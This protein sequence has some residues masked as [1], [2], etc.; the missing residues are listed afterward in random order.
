VAIEHHYQSPTSA[1]IAFDQTIPDVILGNYGFSENGLLGAVG[2]G[3]VHVNDPDAIYDMLPWQRWYALETSGPSELVLAGTSAKSTS[4]TTVTGTGTAYLTEVSAGDELVFPGG[5]VEYLQV[6][7]VTDDTHLELFAAPAHT[8][9][10]QT[11]TRAA[12][13]RIA[14]CWTGADISDGRGEGSGF[15]EF[16]ASGRVWDVSVAD[17]NAALHFRMSRDAA[18]SKTGSIGSATTLGDRL[19]A[20]LAD[21]PEAALIHDDGLVDYPTT[22]CDAQDLRGPYLDEHLNTISQQSRYN[23]SLRYHEAT[24]QIELIVK[25]PLSFYLPSP[26][27]ISNYASDVSS[28][29][30]GLTFPP[31]RPVRNRAGAG[32]MAGVQVTKSTGNVYRSDAATAERYEYRDVSAPQATLKTTAAADAYGDALLDD[33]DSPDEKVTCSVVVPAAKVH[34]FGRLKQIRGR[35]QHITGWEDWQWLRIEQR[36]VTHVPAGDL[37][38]PDHYQVDL[39]LGP[40]DGPPPPPTYS[41]AELNYPQSTGVSSPAL[42]NW[43]GTG[44]A[45]HAG[46]RSPH[47]LTGLMAYDATGVDPSSPTDKTGIKM[48]GSGILDS[49][50]CECPFEFGYT[51][52]SHDVTLTVYKNASVIGSDTY[53]DPGS[54]I[55]V[56]AGGC[57]VDLSGVAVS[58]GDILTA[59]LTFTPTGHGSAI[60][61]AGTNNTIYFSAT[62]SLS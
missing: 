28:D 42:L 16:V 12:Q 44:D 21:A 27:K 25:R 59:Q 5:A 24:D 23:H 30:T 32:I 17:V 8:A 29:A 10:G 56:V 2:T 15:P 61:I 60:P 38:S 36:S 9:S 1:T 26:A 22:A 13:Q 18:W 34:L 43:D 41:Y 14:T 49:V 52:G 35:F 57:L 39:V 31:I 6:A 40:T 48:L 33:G 4:T 11:V 54:G 58:S 7:S 45:P 62:G 51:S 19:A 46:P 3:I 20:I 47:P 37:A 53:L 55:H 50:H